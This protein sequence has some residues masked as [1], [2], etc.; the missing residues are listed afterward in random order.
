MTTSTTNE[1]VRVEKEGKEED[2]K[3]RRGGRIGAKEERARKGKA[4]GV[5]REAAELTLRP[6]VAGRSC[7]L[8]RWAGGEIAVLFGTRRTCIIFII[9]IV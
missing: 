2:D 1:G 4:K 9:L 5:K 7:W 3:R 6:P 8:V